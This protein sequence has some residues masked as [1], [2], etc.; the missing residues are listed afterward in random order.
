[1]SASSAGSPPRRRV[2]RRAWRSRR[3][4]APRPPRG[5]RRRVMPRPRSTPRRPR[6]SRALPDALADAFGVF[7][8][9]ALGAFAFGVGVSSSVALAGL[10]DSSERSRPWLL[11]PQPSRQAPSLPAPRRRPWASSCRARARRSALRDLEDVDAAA[12]SLDLRAGGRGERV[13]DHEE[14]HR[15]LPVTKDL[16]RLVEAPD[17]ARPR[18]G[19][20]G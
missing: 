8:A 2:S 1:M 20:P 13:G 11:L 10:P 4:R 5:R 3:S 9:T 16:Q 19:C 12:R 6:A 18:A 17:Q 15:Q 14:R 7:A